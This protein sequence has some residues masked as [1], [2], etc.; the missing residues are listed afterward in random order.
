MLPNI[1]PL[2]VALSAYTAIEVLT[3]E[4]GLAFLGLSLPAPS[5]TWGGM[6]ADGSAYIRSAWWLVGA[7]SLVI[8]ITLASF[9]TVARRYESASR[10]HGN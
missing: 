5:P 4:S 2:L 8:V 1:R 10:P 3:I 9:L 6:L 7:S